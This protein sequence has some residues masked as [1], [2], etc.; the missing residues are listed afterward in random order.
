MSDSV[1]LEVAKQ[2]PFAVILFAIILVFL[3][4][5]KKVDSARMA[6]EKEMETMR[7]SAAK[8]R[9]I[10]KRTFD[11]QV[12]NMWANSIKNIVD[13]QKETAKMIADSLADHEQNSK[14]RYE[15]MGITRDL[16]EAAR[17]RER[18]SNK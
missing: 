17:D 9:E 12:N 13:G 15:K 18:R 2:I 10:E 6:H 5:L 8:E 4:H 1:L 7:L 16:L 11:T 3:D 14:E